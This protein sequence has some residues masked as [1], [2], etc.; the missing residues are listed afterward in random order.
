V[1]LGVV[2]GKLNKQIAVELGVGE[3]MVKVHRANGMRKMHVRSVAELV[4]A[5]DQ[6][7]GIAAPGGTPAR[8][9]K[10]IAG[11]GNTPYQVD[12]LPGSRQAGP[13]PPS[14]REPHKQIRKARDPYV[15]SDDVLRLFSIS[16]KGCHD[17]LCW[18]LMREATLQDLRIHSHR[19]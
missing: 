17:K 7:T 12:I 18:L 14:G 15:Y 3:V 2:G 1:L 11:E 9:S 6:V 4:R 5:I 16:L 8:D 13:D 10:S 19:N